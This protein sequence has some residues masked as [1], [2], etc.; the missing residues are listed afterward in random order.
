MA[1]TTSTK[2]LCSNCSKA[3]GILTCCGCKKDFCYRHVT[4]HREELNKRMIELNDKS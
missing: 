3:A 2:N 1:F 4:D